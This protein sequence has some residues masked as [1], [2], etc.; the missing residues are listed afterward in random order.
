[1]TTD[2]VSPRRALRATNRTTARPSPKNPSAPR[3]SPVSGVVVAAG[4]V[5][6][7]AVGFGIT[8]IW[9]STGTTPGTTS[10][11]A[12]GVSAAGVPARKRPDAGVSVATCCISFTATPVA[13]ESKTT[14]VFVGI[15]VGVVRWVGRAGGHDRRV[16]VANSTN[17]CRLHDLLG[18]TGTLA[19]AKNHITA[20]TQ[21][22]QDQHAPPSQCNE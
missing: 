9:V 20:D 21:Q 13:V 12:P 15:G 22:T 1:M 18:L 2:Q 4:A 8:T 5:V 14:G 7:V 10:T 3:P 19:A 16:S 11:P 6:G 17:R